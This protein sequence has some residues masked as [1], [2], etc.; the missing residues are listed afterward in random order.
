L[1]MGLFRKSKMAKNDLGDDLGDDFGDDTL[2]AEATDAT[3]DSDE[4]SGGTHAGDSFEGG[5]DQIDLTQELESKTLDGTSECSNGISEEIADVGVEENPDTIEETRAGEATKILSMKKEESRKLCKKK[6]SKKSSSGPKTMDSMGDSLEDMGVSEYIASVEPVIAKPSTPPMDDSSSSLGFLDA[7][8]SS[9]GLSEEGLPVKK[10]KK[11]KSPRSVLQAEDSEGKTK[12]KKSRSSA[13]VIEKPISTE[14]E[15][16]SHSRKSSPKIDAGDDDTKKIKSKSTSKL[17]VGDD[18]VEKSESSRKLDV[19]DN[20]MKKSKQSRKFDA[21]DA[22]SKMDLRKLDVGEKPMRRSS[23]KLDVGET[24]EKSKKKKSKSEKK[25][26]KKSSEDGSEN[27]QDKKKS[28]KLSEDGSAHSEETDPT[29]SAKAA[30]SDSES[31]LSNPVPLES[32]PETPSS[33]ADEKHKTDLKQM[34]SE[35]LYLAKELETERQEI[36]QIKNMMKE[37]AA[38]S[39]KV[40]KA[41]E[42]K[43][44]QT[45]SNSGAAETEN[46]QQPGNL[47]MAKMQIT[48]LEQNLFLHRVE[49]HRLQQ[50]LTEALEKVVKVSE[51]QG[52]V[53][54]SLLVAS[55]KLMETTAALV[56]STAE[57][58]DLKA[59]LAERNSE[60]EENKKRIASLEKAVETQLDNQDALE[61]KLEAAD[62]EIDKMETEMKLLDEEIVVL[63]TRKE[64]LTD[65]SGELD[66]VRRVQDDLQMTVDEQV[67]LLDERER[68]IKTLEQEMGEHSDFLQKIETLTQENVGLQGKL[69]SEQLEIGVRLSKK[70]DAIASLQKEMALMKKDSDSHVSGDFTVMSKELKQCQKQISLAR[71]DLEDAQRRIGFLEEENEDLQAANGKLKGELKTLERSASE[72]GTKAE[73]MQALIAHWT[74]KTFEW[75]LR[76]ETAEKKLETAP[77][78]TGSDSE[79]E[80]PQA[81]FLQAAM[82]KKRAGGSTPQNKQGTKWAM[83]RRPSDDKS[84]EF[85]SEDALI[86]IEHRN[87]ILEEQIAKLQS[88][89]VKLQ[90]AYK[91]ESYTNTKKLEQLQSDNSVYSE[92]NAALVKLVGFAEEQQAAEGQFECPTVC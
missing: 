49:T 54:D 7:S 58:S 31:A 4:H 47:G 16:T 6:V 13:S 23:K 59:K 18:D 24:D 67:L 11:N 30:D 50:Q 21:G 12:K 14:G 64:E 35:K 53:K 29:S 43:K 46:E 71:D 20:E 56:F 8:S 88:D 89:M 42:E 55:T 69:K 79:E 32:V 40:Q 22:D 48:G 75:K 84:S 73:E 87:E 82:D 92:K 66:E 51:D 41:L 83:F 33:N 62:E 25:K 36:A 9:L 28:K 91:E 68:K 80:A 90:T 45:S 44:A 26:N 76:A 85:N 60:V 74:E 19:G 65:L 5:K 70:S 3:I 72:S 38:E 15:G 10:K 39:E 1:K 17:D 52:R 57:V 78:G 34:E 27:S 63:K 61:V 86:K 81:L 2:K 37:Q 77:A